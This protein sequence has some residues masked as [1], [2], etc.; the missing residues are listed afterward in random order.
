VG[1]ERGVGE[2]LWA[3][4]EGMIPKNPLQAAANGD[5][6]PLIFFAL[7]LGVFLSLV[8][9][10]AG[11][12]HEASD[13]EGAASK[14]AE[15]QRTLRENIALV[16]RFFDGFF[17]VMM[18]LTLAVVALAPIGVFGFMLSAAAGHG[19]AAFEALGLY[20][21][22]VFAG[23]L[24]HAGVTLPTIVWVFAK[25]SPLQHVKT[26]TPALLTAFSTASSN[27]TL[28]L[29]MKCV[30]EAGVPNEVSSFV[31][32]LGATINMDGTALYEAVAVVFLFQ[33]YGVQ[34]SL[35]ELAVVVATATLAAVGAAGIP[36]AGLVTMV[37]V[38][39]AVNASLGSEKVPV[40]AMGI[41]IGVDRLLDMCRTTV[42]V[43]G[44]MGAA[45]IMTRIAPD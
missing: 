18:R 37:I 16:R 1:Q 38:I 41:V 24:L 43:W 22:T 4:L 30:E 10:G 13:R 34:L 33:L 11:P 27:G 44:D 17:A 8:E 9:H 15:E 32:P 45:R 28:P 14:E 20:A 42:N 26:M 23:L 39:T 35:G 36:S 40:G 25:R 6:L 5:I 19:L 31:L 12:K 7:V 21:L 29:T 3:Q 2:V